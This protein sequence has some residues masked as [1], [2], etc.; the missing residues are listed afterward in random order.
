MMAGTTVRKM[1]Q[2]K[3]VTPPEPPPSLTAATPGFDETGA[4]VG[5]TDYRVRKAAGTWKIVSEEWLGA[6]EGGSRSSG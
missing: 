1:Q 6:W 5:G 2:A 4:H 3:L